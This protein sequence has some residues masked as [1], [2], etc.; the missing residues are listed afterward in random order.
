MASTTAPSS[1]STL[2]NRSCVIGRAILMPSSSVAI[3]V[4]SKRPI[5]IGRFSL[6]SES[7]RITIGVLVT[8]SSVSPPTVMRMNCSRPMRGDPPRLESFY[9]RPLRLPIGNALGSLDDQPIDHVIE[10]IQVA[11]LLDHVAE[12][13]VALHLA[14]AEAPRHLALG[15]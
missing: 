2:R 14:V 6:F 13:P 4:A 15:V 5:Q 3:A 8:G 9:G 7:L 10:L 12:R 1:P 11:A